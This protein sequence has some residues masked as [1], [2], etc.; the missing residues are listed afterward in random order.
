MLR[1]RSYIT[2]NVCKLKISQRKQKLGSCSITNVVIVKVP[3][4]GGSREVQCIKS[5]ILGASQYTTAI[6]VIEL[7]F[8]AKIHISESTVID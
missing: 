1:Y 6:H 7:G 3:H 8:M 2:C 4:K 5:N